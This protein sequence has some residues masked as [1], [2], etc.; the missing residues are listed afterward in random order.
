MSLL[1]KD[2]THLKASVLTRF[3]R[4]H[5]GFVFQSYNC[6]LSSGCL[7]FWREKS[8]VVAAG[9]RPFERLA[10]FSYVVLLHEGVVSAP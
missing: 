6:V 9:F 2:I 4:R 1:G 3:R 10:G 7:P 5:L 8:S